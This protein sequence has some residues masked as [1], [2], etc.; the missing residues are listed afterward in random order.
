LQRIIYLPL[1]I[2]VA[3]QAPVKK[4]LSRRKSMVLQ[5]VDKPKKDKVAIKV[6]AKSG[7]PPIAE[8]RQYFPISNGRRWEWNVQW[9]ENGIPK[10][11]SVHK[12]NVVGIKKLSDE[13]DYFR[14]FYS[15]E[16]I[17]SGQ[18]PS[19]GEIFQRVDADKG[20]FVRRTELARENLS[21]PFPI[22]KDMT[23]SLTQGQAVTTF[24]VIGVETVKL[25]SRTYESCLRIES[26]SKSSN[27]NN[28][29]S[30]VSY[31]AKGIGR[32]LEISEYSRIGYVR[33]LEIK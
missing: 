14:I 16:H 27:P 24:K 1:I 5:S 13:K 19:R 8:Y 15:T 17:G 30:S 20:V 2:F 3:C 7:E 26:S 23:W 29:N 32:I 22:R 12:E 31:Y 10:V 4:P 9:L 18:E 21:I 28:D 6:E 25:K 33:R 11:R